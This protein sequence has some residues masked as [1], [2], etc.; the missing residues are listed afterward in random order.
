MVNSVQVR[1]TCPRSRRKPGALVS[2]NSSNKYVYVDDFTTK[3]EFAVNRIFL[4]SLR[5]TDID[6]CSGGI[7]SCL[8][9]TATCTNTVGSYTCACRPGYEGDGKTSCIAPGK[10]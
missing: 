7:H 1:R 4:S 9:D 5:H 3:T 6:E 2:I 10:M 8:M